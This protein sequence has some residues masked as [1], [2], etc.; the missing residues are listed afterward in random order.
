MDIIGKLN[1]GLIVSCQ[2][3]PGSPLRL[4]AVMAAMAKAA[5]AGG[6]L[7]IRANGSEDI[8]AIRA[9]VDLPIIGIF[10]NERPGFDVFI[11]STLQDACAVVAAGADIVAM[12]AT[13]RTRP[14][15]LTAAQAIRFYKQELKVPV[16]ADISTLEE[17]LAAAEAGADLVATTLSGY[18]L[19]SQQQA[20]PD[21]ALVSELAERITVP[22][23]AEGRISSPQAARRALDCGAYAVVVG[24]A[25]TAVDWVTSQYARAIKG[26][27]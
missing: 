27:A 17:G 24:T 13:L 26:L 7:G 4:P 18:T 1:Q 22:V 19:Y 5:Q 8:S 21:L 20:E 14:D 15:G 12:D 11:T 10:K 25:I 6:A 23:I 16:M 2:A 9:A 3:R